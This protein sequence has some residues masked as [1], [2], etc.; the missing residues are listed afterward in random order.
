[1]AGRREGGRLLFRRQAHFRGRPVPHGLMGFVG[2]DLFSNG[3]CGLRDYNSR[4][5]PRGHSWRAP[6]RRDLG[7]ESGARAKARSAA[8]WRRGAESRHL[9]WSPRDARAAALKTGKR[10]GVFGWDGAWPSPPPSV[11]RRFRPGQ[12]DSRTPRRGS[13]ELPGQRRLG[14]GPGPGHPEERRSG[15]LSRTE[16]P[17][18]SWCPASRVLRA[19]A[20]TAARPS[21]QPSGG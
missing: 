7:R 2:R 15:T 21:S 5:A 12:G 8:D 18:A 1:M 19:C 11:R 13:R 3:V 17:G 4:R 10:D 16:P 20:V 9:L 6:R 14:P